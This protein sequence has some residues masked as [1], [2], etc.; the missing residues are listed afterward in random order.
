MPTFRFRLCAREQS[1]GRRV[2]GWL[3]AGGARGWPERSP[4]RWACA[5][6]PRSQPSSCPRSALRHGRHHLVPRVR[7]PRDHHRELWLLPVCG[8]DWRRA[9]P[10]GG[11]CH[12]LL[13]WGRPGVRG[14]SLLLLFR[15]QFP[16]PRQERARIRQLPACARRCCRCRAPG[17]RFACQPRGGGRPTPL[18]GSKAKVLEEHPGWHSAVLTSPSPSV[19]LKEMFSSDN[20]AHF[21]PHG[22]A[23]YFCHTYI[24]VYIYMYTHTYILKIFS[25]LFKFQISCKHCRVGCGERNK[26]HLQTVTDDNGS[27]IEMPLFPPSSQLRGHLDITNRKR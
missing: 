10:R 25:S 17:P 7:P 14:K 4:A 15:L 20:A 1:W 9:V 12:R 13:R 16:Y 22:F 18:P 8:L 27:L 2:W 6:A 26:R 11:L 5:G 24:Y 3:E 19:A 21:P 23:H